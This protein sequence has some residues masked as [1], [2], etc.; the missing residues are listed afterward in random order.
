MRAAQQVAAGT[1]LPG[2]SSRRGI[3]IVVEKLP[4]ETP[5]RIL[6]GDLIEAEPWVPLTDERI[7]STTEEVPDRLE[8]AV[9]RTSRK[10][11]DRQGADSK[12][13]WRGV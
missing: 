11:L 9:R 1:M 4:R 12:L 13:G 8:E 6:V 5:R 2:A 3:L 7:C 10:Q